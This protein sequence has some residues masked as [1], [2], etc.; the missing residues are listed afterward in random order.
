MPWLSDNNYGNDDSKRSFLFSL[1]NKTKHVLFAN[2]IYAIYNNPGYGPTYGGGHDV[3]ISN[4]CNINTSSYS[5]FGYC[6]KSIDSA[7]YGGLPAQSYMAGSYNFKVAEYEVY[8]IIP[9]L[10]E[11]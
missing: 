3:Y 2:P 8:E 10:R 11:D 1:T 7:P 6:Y 9:V 4:D 5:N